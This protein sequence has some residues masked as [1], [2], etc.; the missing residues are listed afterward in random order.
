MA[1]LTRIVNGHPNSD[2]DKLLRDPTESQTSNPTRGV[3]GSS[4]FGRNL[5]SRFFI[6][7]EPRASN[8]LRYGY[9]LRK[10]SLKSVA[11]S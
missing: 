11:V 3:Q 1:I 7:D 6:L 10:F 4:S 2:I 9:T 8:R 5:V